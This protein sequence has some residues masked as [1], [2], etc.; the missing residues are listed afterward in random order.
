MSTLWV[1]KP[2]GE[3][4]LGLKA[5]GRRGK[6]SFS[7]VREFEP[8]ELRNRAVIALETGV[9]VYF[10]RE[11]LTKGP[12][13][14]LALQAEDKVREAGFFTGAFRVVFHRLSEGPV[15]IEVGLLALEPAGVEELLQRLGRVQARLKGL[16]HET[17]A[18]AYLVAGWLREPVLAARLSEEGLWLVVSEGG[19]PTYMRF[20]AVDE[21]LGLEGMPVEENVLAVLD[22]YER[23][24]GKPIRYL[25]PCGPYR[26]RLAE[27]GHLEILKPSL[28]NIKAREE[29]LLT[30]PELFGA[31]LVPGDYNLLP[32]NH[33]Y[34]LQ[35]L[36]WVRYAGGLLFL[37]TILNYGLFAY[38]YQRNRGLDQE[39]LQTSRTLERRLAELREEYPPEQIK[40][41]K[42]Y[43][44]WKEKFESQPRMDEFLWWL[45]QKLPQGV[46]VTRVEVKKGASGDYR[47]KLGLVFEGPLASARKIFYRF[48]DQIKKRARIE[49]SRF[50]Y[51][52]FQKQAR[53]ELEVG[54]K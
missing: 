32:E 12:R 11:T 52:E 36:E 17:M 41:L 5:S 22:Y 8:V 3:K 53:F 26:D 7:E 49:A 47:M 16:Y 45:A 21:F 25:F 20:Q 18:L 39:V 23:F 33:R 4:F 29:D 30:Y 31:V 35:A 15:N 42:V 50:D 1:I 34:F 46:R 9:Q 40:K 43:L 54:L 51:D 27:A 19:H 28:E 38:L 44:E 24:F 13:E 6:W 37:L 2:R 14:I 48:F 10:A